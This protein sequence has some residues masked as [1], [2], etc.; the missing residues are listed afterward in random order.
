MEQITFTKEFLNEDFFKEVLF[1]F[2]SESGAMFDPGMVR[3]WT[4]NGV[5]YVF[6]YMKGEPKYS[7]VQEFFPALGKH[8]NDWEHEYL[9]LGAHLFVHSSVYPIFKALSEES[10]GS[11]R[12]KWY[13]LIKKTL[14]ELRKNDDTIV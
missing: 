6:N 7:E 11:T 3:F 5:E 2:D 8:H 13:V 1:F 4:K 10:T 12:F 9:G 14:T